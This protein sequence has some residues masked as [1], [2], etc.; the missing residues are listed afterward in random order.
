MFVPD[1]RKNLFSIGQ[2]A[3][4]GYHTI[5]KRNG[6]YI[7]S[8]EGQGSVAIV[9]TRCAKLYELQIKVLE[10]PVMPRPSPP[11]TILGTAL[12]AQS[13][14]V[15]H[16]RFCHVHP[17]VLI[18][19]ANQSTVRGLDIGTR[20]GPSTCIGCSLGKSHR[21]PFPKRSITPR[22]LQPGAFFHSDVCGPMHVPSIGGARYILLFK[23]D[24]S[25]YRVVY[26]IQRKS[27]VM[28]CFQKLLELTVK[29]TGNP[30]TRLRSDMGGE[31]MSHEFRQY[32]EE[33]HICH[34]V[35]APYSPQQNGVSERENRTLMEAIRSMLHGKSLPLNLWGEAAQTAAH[36]LNHI[37]TRVHHFKSPFELWTGR[38]PDVAHFRIFG[39][40]AYAH[41]PS[42]L[43]KKLDPKSIRTIVVGY[44]PFSRAYRLW[45][46]SKRRILISRDVSFAEDPFSLESADGLPPATPSDAETLMI[47]GG[48]DPLLETAPP[49]VTHPV[50]DVTI[51]DGTHGGDDHVVP[52]IAP[53]SPHRNGP[54]PAAIPAS[55]QRS[56]RLRGPPAH[57]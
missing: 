55:V 6:C 28:G 54:P 2:A 16:Q 31:Y 18:R 47:W 25:S 36:V 1:L 44:S 41:I 56:N 13:L 39:S 27:E 52:D 24:Y 50:P 37:A 12:A 45:C 9:G 29:D 38:V 30:I 32:L 4:K 22:A 42:Q 33:K 19:M 23:D 48:P 43:R 15:W 46:P 34:E 49:V 26:T 20:T 40:V 51:P 57:L 3:D 21:M 14:E 35:T 8:N 53:L 11:L 17:D 7:I 10:P 5:Y